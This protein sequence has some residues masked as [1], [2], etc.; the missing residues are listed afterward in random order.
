[1]RVYKAIHKTQLAEDA[2]VSIT[3]LQKWIKEQHDKL[4]GDVVL[5]PRAKVLHPLAVKI[6]SEYYCIEPRNSYL[7]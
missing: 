2:G 1:M 3:T 7:I 4:Q 5:L 6:L